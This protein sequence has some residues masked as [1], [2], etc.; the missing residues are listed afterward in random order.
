MTTIPTKID[1]PLRWGIIGAG[2]IARHAI[3]P[4]IRDS[5]NGTLHAIA[6]RGASKALQ[7]AAEL[8]VP[9]SCARYEEL[10]SRDDIDAVYLGLPN[11][12]HE[13]WV[14]KA[15]AAGKHV[16]CEKSLALTSAAAHRMRDTCH[17]H[18]VLL[19]EAFMYRH[20]PQWVRVRELIQQGVIGEIQSISAHL[21]GA[22]GNDQDHRWSAELGGGALFDVTCYGINAAR[23]LLGTE[24]TRV[25]AT[26][27]LRS[28]GV[29]ETTHVLLEFPGEILAS[30]Q[31][32]LVGHHAQ[33]LRIIGTK[34]VIDVERP[35]VCHT[36]PA[37]LR[38]TTASNSEE[39]TLPGANQFQLEVEHFAHCILNKTSLQY[40]AE[41]G[42]K[43][44][45]VCE[46]AALGVGS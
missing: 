9:H 43:N 15:A 18:G 41:D 22:L 30:A 25:L 10:L 21:C 20:H 29:D 38:L 16:L 14:L 35:F 26:A 17:S 27:K 13:E 12:L 33:G 45:T 40:P 31:G 28:Q 44:T 4:A 7:L 5:C 2:N 36:D 8:G 11:G 42:V 23:Y 3:A 32:S 39:I 37:K 1:R 46:R 19:M 34:G 6:S 24:P